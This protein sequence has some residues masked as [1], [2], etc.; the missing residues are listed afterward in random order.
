MKLKLHAK[1]KVA[2]QLEYLI[3]KKF[4]N[5]VV[6]SLYADNKKYLSSISANLALRFS[7]M[8]MYLSVH[9]L[10]AMAAIGLIDAPK[11]MLGPYKINVLNKEFAEIAKN[12]MSIKHNPTW[13][14]ET[15]KWLIDKFKSNVNDF[16]LKDNWI[17]ND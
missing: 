16:F 12:E 9:S 14:G 1:P 6:M 4:N 2:N 3:N 13:S 7:P 15:G 5:I 17:N 11:N 8:K 10:V